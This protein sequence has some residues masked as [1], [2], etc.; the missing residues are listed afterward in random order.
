MNDTAATPDALQ[1]AE[2]QRAHQRQSDRIQARTTDPGNSVWVSAN[3]GS[4]KTYQLSRRVIRLM[5]EGARPSQLLCL[6]FTKAAAAEMSNR[7]F[8]ILGEWTT[9]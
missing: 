5:L 2:Q 4:G 8:G 1:R 9:M 7:V 3:A 6:T